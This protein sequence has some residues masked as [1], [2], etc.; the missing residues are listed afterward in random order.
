MASIH[1]IRNSAYSDA[2][3]LTAL[4]LLNADDL[5]VFIDDGVYNVS[6]PGIQQLLVNNIGIQVYVIE[7]HI[8]ARGI[9]APVNI[10]KITMANLV[11]LTDQ[12]TQVITWQ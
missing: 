1:L 2:N 9:T 10:E 8:Q 12:S 7:H 3:I 4:S 6:H 5:V 11:A